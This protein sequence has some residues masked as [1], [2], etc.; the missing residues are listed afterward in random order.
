MKKNLQK[1]QIELCYGNTCLA[2]DG[3]NA[4]MITIGIMFLLL[5]MGVSFIIKSQSL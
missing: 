4:Q 3:K 1:N 2:A 5:M